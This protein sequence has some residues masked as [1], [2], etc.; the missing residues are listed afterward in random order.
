[1]TANALVMDLHRHLS[2]EPVTARPRSRLY[3][4]EKTV[5]RHKVGFAAAGAIMLSLF[6]CLGIAT[7]SLIKERQAR[8]RADTEAAKNVQIARFLENMLRGI[9]PKAAQ[10]RDTTL[11][12][13]LLSHTEGQVSQDLTNQPSVEA[14][15]KNTI[16]NIYASLGEFQNAETMARNALALRE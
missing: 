2:N 3:V 16:G 9:D 15:L 12:R 6:L 7:W 1:E 8:W 14:H 13:E 4:L 11:L 5:R 10:E